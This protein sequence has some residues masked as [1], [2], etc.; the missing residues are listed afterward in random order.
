MMEIRAHFTVVLQRIDKNIIKETDV[1]IKAKIEPRNINIKVTDIYKMP[2]YN[3]LK[4]RLTNNDMANHIKE[5]NHNIEYENFTDI[6]NVQCMHCYKYSHQNR[7]C[8]YKDTVFC[9]NCSA[10]DH[11]WRNCRNSTHK[12]LNCIGPYPALANSCPARKAA[13]K[14]VKNKPI[15]EAATETIQAAKDVC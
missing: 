7:N 8:P 13:V 5:T 9:S 11:I 14:T 2:D 3:M 10:T 4:V 6:S 12:C 1:E 15:I